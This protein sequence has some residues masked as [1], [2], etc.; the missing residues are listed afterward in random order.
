M[1]EPANKQRAA[2]QQ[3]T[4]KK[5]CVLKEARNDE[6]CLFLFEEMIYELFISLWLLLL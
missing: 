1:N 4:K 2:E 3:Q 5:N 6:K